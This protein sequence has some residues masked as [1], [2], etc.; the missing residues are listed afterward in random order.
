MFSLNTV[1]M[2]SQ[3]TEDPHWWLTVILSLV[4][5]I[6][7]VVAQKAYMVFYR[8]RPSQL[9]QEY[10]YKH[11]KTLGL[12]N[13]QSC[14]FGTPESVP[15]SSVKLNQVQM[16]ELNEQDGDGEAVK[17]NKDYEK[18]ILGIAKTGNAK[19]EV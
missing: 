19:A 17:R 12:S 6:L 10:Q 5:C 16:V 14:C 7:P 15:E 8:P 9:M 13:R 2:L 1:G 11:E 3:L 18:R 4:S